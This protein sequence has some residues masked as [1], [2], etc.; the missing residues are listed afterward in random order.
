MV[1]I[2]FAGKLNKYTGKPL[3]VTFKEPE[4]KSTLDDFQ[5]RKCED[6]GHTIEETPNTVMGH[7]CPSCIQFAK[8]LREFD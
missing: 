4:P 5:G 7:K 1:N 6:C 8:T 2:L 3:K